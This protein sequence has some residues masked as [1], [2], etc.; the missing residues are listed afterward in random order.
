V[1]VGGQQDALGLGI[2]SEGLLEEIDAGHTGHALVGEEEGDGIVAVLELAADIERRTAG[3]RPDD[4][5]VLAIVTAKILDYSLQDTGVV[6]DSEQDRL[7]HT[8]VIL[9]G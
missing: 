1:G 9:R 7:R 5:V 4:T 2:D 3:R 6:V 8:L